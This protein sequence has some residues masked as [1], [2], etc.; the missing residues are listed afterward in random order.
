MASLRQSNPFST[1]K[2]WSPGENG[3]GD[4][5]RERDGRRTE[6][7]FGVQRERRRRARAWDG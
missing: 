1:G 2:G 3:V 6:H 7:G 5:M 4:T